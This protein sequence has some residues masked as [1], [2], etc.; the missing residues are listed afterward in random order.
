MKFY[1]VKTDSIMHSSK[2]GYQKWAIAIYLCVTHPKG[3]SSHQL[4]KDLGIT[5]K[6]AWHLGH[7]IRKALE[8]EDPGIFYGPVEVDETFIGVEHVTSQ[9]NGSA[10]WRRYQLSGC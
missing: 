2:L 8:T 5:Q 7:R 3:I 9:Q 6:T 4:S 10:D 1:S